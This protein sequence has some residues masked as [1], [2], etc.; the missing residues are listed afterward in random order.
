[1]AVVQEAENRAPGSNQ[2]KFQVQGQSLFGYE[3]GRNDTAD[4]KYKAKEI[5]KEAHTINL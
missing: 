3:V 2:Y 1:M 5:R 4:K